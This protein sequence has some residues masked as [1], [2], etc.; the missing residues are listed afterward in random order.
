M[1][2]VVIFGGSGFIG[3]NIIRRLAKREYLIIVPHQT[4]INDSK[5]RLY[6]NVGQIMPIKFK[7]LGENKIKNIINRTDIVINLKTI[8]REKKNYSYEKNILNFNIQLVDL[9]NRTNKNKVFIFFSGI[10]ESKQSSSKRVNYIAKTEEYITNNIKNALII[11]PSVVIGD[12]DQ[13]LRKILPII[14]YCFLIPLFGD[15][16]TKLQPVFVD[17][18]ANAVEVI[19]EKETKENNIYELVGLEIF[20]YKSLYQFISNSLGLKRKF[21][22]ISFGLASI[23]VSILERTPL[24][25]I[26]KDQ[27][28][29]F[30]EDNISSNKHK[31]FNSLRISPR[32]IQEIIKKIIVQ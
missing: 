32:D 31:N 20:T 28:L 25:L 17:D 30:K 18:V 16:E 19:L 27:L 22:P 12:G 9:I 24:N 2:T 6:G 23:V 14:R 3:Q 8:W 5:L 10:G 21:I 11:R 7:K 13:F 26:T 1:K 15:G 29:L 4:S